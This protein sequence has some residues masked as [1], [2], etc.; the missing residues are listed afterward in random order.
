M[1]QNLESWLSQNNISHF[2]L[3][4]FK[5]FS[6]KEMKKVSRVVVLKET[7]YFLKPRKI[8]KKKKDWGS[9]GIYLQTQS[10]IIHFDVV[11]KN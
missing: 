8:K 7:I 11:Q 2:V 1:N 5:V 3:F 9:S 10:N 6:I 4:L